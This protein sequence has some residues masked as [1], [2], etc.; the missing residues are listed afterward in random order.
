MCKNCYNAG[1]DYARS[2]DQNDPIIIN[3]RTLCVEDEDMTCRKIWQMT[4]MPIAA[5]SLEQAEKL[6]AS[7]TGLL[8]D[9]TS[10][11]NVKASTEGQN[12]TSETSSGAK[13]G[14]EIDVVTTEGFRS[15]IFTEV[16]CLRMCAL[17]L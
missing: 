8:N 1:I 9:R 10:Q 15:K 16:S 11:A 13:L 7:R 3:G 17:I 2:H 12:V 4:S 5:A 14:E 6:G